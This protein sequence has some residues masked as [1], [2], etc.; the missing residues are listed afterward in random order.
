MEHR[1]NRGGERKSIAAILQ[2]PAIKKIPSGIWHADPG[3]TVRAA[4]GRQQKAA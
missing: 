2:Q 3:A 1:P 4:R